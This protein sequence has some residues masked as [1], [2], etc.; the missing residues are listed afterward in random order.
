MQTI[1]PIEIKQKSF[2]KSFRGY[3]PDEVDAF[4]HALAYAWEK[5]TTQLDELKSTIEIDRREI[6]RLQGI[7]TALLQAVKS[8][9]AT[10]RNITEQ[11][12]TEAELKVREAK[13]TAD[14][15]IR[16]AQEKI[17][18]IERDNQRKHTH[19][20]AQIAQ[21]SAKATERIQEAETYRNT[22]LQTLRRLA[23]D[24]L[25]S[26]QVEKN[27]Q[28]KADTDKTQEDAHMEQASNKEA[29]ISTL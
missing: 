4:L 12:Q 11:A 26:T 18:T 27:V 9:E 20:K 28:R 22:L 24:I 2:E 3:K 13:I 17:N 23:E 5:L 21:E 29:A 1:T 8:V 19:L 16:E 10:T 25:K 6:K 14:R 15:L 7:E